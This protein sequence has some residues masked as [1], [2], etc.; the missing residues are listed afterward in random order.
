[1]KSL[2][3]QQFIDEI[4]SGKIIKAEFQVKN[5]AHYKHCS[6]ER[7]TDVLKN[8]NSIVRIDVKLTNDESEHIGFYKVFKEN[9][10]L[11][12]MGCKGMFTL[13][14]MWDEI[15]FIKIDYSTLTI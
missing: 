12:N 9:F 4:N 8:G 13:K 1:M 6:I 11:F 7:I 14:Q 15:E 2:T 3:Y 10:K 5:Y